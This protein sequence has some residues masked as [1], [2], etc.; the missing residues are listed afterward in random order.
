IERKLEQLGYE[1]AGRTSTGESAIRLVD[2]VLPDLVLMDIKLEGR[3]DGIEAAGEIRKRHDIPIVFLT[4]YAD[5]ATLQRAT[6]QEPFGYIV[7]PFTDRELTGAIEV[8]LHRH[9]LDKAMRAREQRYR[10]LS[11]V[12]SDY[13]FC[14]SIA[15][16]PEN[17]ELEWSVGSV[18]AVFGVPLENL[19][20]IEDALY[21]VHPDDAPLVQSFWQSLRTGKDGK[22][23][24]R[25]MPGDGSL[26]WVKMD[27]K[28]VMSR[29]G[30]VRQVYGAYQNITELRQ[31]RERL[32]EREF[33]FSRIVQTV[34]QGIWVGDS[35]G[36]SIYVNQAL[37]DLTGHT[38]DHLVGRQSLPTILSGAGMQAPEGESF[39]AELITR[40][41]NTV[42]VLVTHRT[43]RGDA[44]EL[45][46]SF[47]LFVDISSQRRAVDALERGRRKLQEVFHA[48]PAPSLL[49][50]SA[51][52]A[53]LDVNDAFTR[54][55]GFSAE[56]IVGTGGFGLAEYQKLE[57]LNRMVAL[58]KERTEQTSQVRLRTKDEE[59]RLFNVEVR[60]IV[61]EDEE[62]LL[63]ILTPIP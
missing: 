10:M 21:L 20:T 46:G 57:D 19:R 6:K 23:E 56:E 63:L 24:F 27:G 55:T 60:D 8:A 44:N 54:T 45:L 12:L 49:I 35:E 9:A 14:I 33:E 30:S 4:A 29:D 39:E 61:V 43:I 7:K 22:I 3:M 18:E 48:S 40:R 13:A 28:V 17:D 2:S 36:A 62:I 1:V 5:E 51:T 47:F 25:I 31:T 16:D 11:E 32:A 34:K 52:N 41:G 42:P 53:V 38:R 37:C 15:P 50:D 26:R 58:L 59:P